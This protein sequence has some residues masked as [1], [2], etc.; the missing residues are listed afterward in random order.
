M[1]NTNAL[2]ARRVLMSGS[3]DTTAHTT[4]FRRA[5]WLFPIC[6]IR[7][8]EL[9]IGNIKFCWLGDLPYRFSYARVSLEEKPMTLTH[10]TTIGG[11]LIWVGN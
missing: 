9:F 1:L 6:W 11:L 3:H 5:R 8:G 4:K 7:D 10:T 2:L